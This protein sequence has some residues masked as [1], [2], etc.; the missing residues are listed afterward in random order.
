MVLKF[1]D[2]ISKAF[3]RFETVVSFFIDRVAFYDVRERLEEG[4]GN[5]RVIEVVRELEA[6]D[7]GKNEEHGQKAGQFVHYHTLVMEIR[8]RHS[9]VMAYPN[10]NLPRYVD[11]TTFLK[12]Y[13]K[14][15]KFNST[16]KK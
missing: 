6:Y 1:D 11:E 8:H 12:L 7:E 9:G 16:Q 10:T 15:R 14:K 2:K 3:A 5:E 4:E 13:K